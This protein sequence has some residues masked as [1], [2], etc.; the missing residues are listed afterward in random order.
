MDLPDFLRIHQYQ[1]I[2]KVCRIHPLRTMTVCFNI[3]MTVN[4]TLLRYL[5]LVQSAEPTTIHRFLA[6]C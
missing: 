6:Y 5:S 1:V 2:T 4:P 3:L